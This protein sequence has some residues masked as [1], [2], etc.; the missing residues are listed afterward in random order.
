MSEEKSEEKPDPLDGVPLGAGRV[1]L[2]EIRPNTH[3]V[4]IKSF[5]RGVTVSIGCAEFA[6]GN[7]SDALAVIADYLDNPVELEAAFNRVS[8]A[9]ANTIWMPTAETICGTRCE[10][11][12]RMGVTHGIQSEPSTDTNSY[13]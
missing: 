11:Q 6:F 4:T 1:L 2:R 12:P 10:S 5:H 13:E 8:G 7:V 3:P 9:P